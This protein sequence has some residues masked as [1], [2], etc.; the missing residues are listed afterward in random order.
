MGEV[1]IGV[2]VCIP[3][4]LE[5]AGK[6]RV[7]LLV[8]PSQR[9]HRRLLSSPSLQVRD[10]IAVVDSLVGEDGSGSELRIVLDE[11]QIPSG[12]SGGGIGSWEV[13]VRRGDAC[14]VQVEGP[15]CGEV[16]PRADDGFDCELAAFLSRSAHPAQPA[17]VLVQDLPGLASAK[18]DVRAG[19]LE[20]GESRERRV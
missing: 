10:L 4:F 9:C 15:D 18:D 13:E 3:H 5:Q 20:L 12:D 16:G 19:P 2:G 14:V 8:R 1:G 17:L 11:S 6:L 7:L